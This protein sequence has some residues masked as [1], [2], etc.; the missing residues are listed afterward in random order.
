MSAWYYRTSAGAEID[1]VVEVNS[2]RR[3][4]IEIKRSLAPTVSKGFYLGSED[5]QA[6]KRFVVYAGSEQFPIAKNVTA[7][8]LADMMRE[9]SQS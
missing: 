2:R 5:I 3:Y 1:L 7:I 8:S 6:T 9:L 4:A